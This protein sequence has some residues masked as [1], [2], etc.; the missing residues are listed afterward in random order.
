VEAFHEYLQHL[1]EKK[2]KRSILSRIHIDDP[3]TPEDIQES[4]RQIQ[5]QHAQK[6]S[7]KIMKKVLGPMVTVLKDYYGI[8]DTLGMSLLPS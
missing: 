8:I 3:P 4:M 2:A 7:V 1:S 6:P 5:L